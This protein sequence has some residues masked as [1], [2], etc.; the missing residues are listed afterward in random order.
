MRAFVGIIKE[1]L[2]TRTATLK[3]SMKQQR[4]LAM[5]QELANMQLDELVRARISH[6][7]VCKCATNDHACCNL[8]VRPFV[9]LQ[10][11]FANPVPRLGVDFQPKGTEENDDP[12]VACLR[13][14]QDRITAVDPRAWKATCQAEEIRAAVQAHRARRP[15]VELRC[16]HRSFFGRCRRAEGITFRRVTA[17]T[18]SRQSTQE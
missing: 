2:D 3:V 11:G 5:N 1:A 13:S 18:L 10:T 8:G 15:R 9:A 4:V 7:R 6:L 17:T 14:K 16:R 12:K